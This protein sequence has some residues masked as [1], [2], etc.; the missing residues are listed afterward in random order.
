LAGIIAGRI[1]ENYNK[2]VIVFTDGEE[3]AK[4][5]GRSIEA[6]N[7][8]EELSKFKDLFIKFGGHPMAAGLSLPKENID[9]L[10]R[11]L[12]EVTT[13]TEED[14]VAKIMIDVPMPIHYITEDL[15]EQLELLEP[16]GKA[17]EKP[18][19][20]EKSLQILNGRILGKNS[21]VLKLRLQN[22]AGCQMDGMYFGNI[23]KII[24][25][26]TTQ[27]GQEEWDKILFGRNNSVRL[28]I[29][30]YPTINEYNGSRSIQV[31]IKN[32]K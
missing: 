5:S 12:N 6:Y 27:Y 25:H 3:C 24:G 11:N 26:I 31:V 30:Y 21:N 22:E 1:R 10:R 17:N 4:G 16:F 14:L 15:V 32:F 8:F 13:L 19:F 7:M 18:T 23:D 28:D 9:I 20:A 29:T 2:P